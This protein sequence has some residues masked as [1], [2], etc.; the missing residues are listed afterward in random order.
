VRVIRSQPGES[1]RKE[2]GDLQASVQHAVE[3][4]AD[5]YTLEVYSDCPYA[6]HLERGTD[7]IARR[8]AWEPAVEAAIDAH[9]DR[10]VRAVEGK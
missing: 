8:P 9:L 10:L 6:P 7:Q 2:T 4:D 3:A 1:P 5:V